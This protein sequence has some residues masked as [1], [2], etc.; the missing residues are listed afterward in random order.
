VS[1]IDVAIRATTPFFGFL[2]VFAAAGRFAFDLGAGLD[3][4][5]AFDFFAVVAMA[6]SATPAAIN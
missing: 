6:D 2:F 4:V 1:A 5:F 3:F